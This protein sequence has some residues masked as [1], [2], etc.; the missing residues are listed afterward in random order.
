MNRAK[1][2][3]HFFVDRYLFNNLENFRIYRI[4]MFLAMKENMKIKRFVKNYVA[5]T[6]YS[7]IFL[8]TVF[9]VRI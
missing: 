9:M 8:H 7:I 5:L 2:V 4:V 1:I 3:L 6:G